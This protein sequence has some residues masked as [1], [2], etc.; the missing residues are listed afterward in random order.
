MLLKH[1]SPENTKQYGI[2]IHGEAV[3]NNA[4]TP[5][6]ATPSKGAAI[7]VA[8]YAFALLGPRTPLCYA[9]LHTTWSWYI[10]RDRHFA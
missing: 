2:S 7:T 10:V 6:L 8:R 4:H 3:V 1:L 9:E 5:V